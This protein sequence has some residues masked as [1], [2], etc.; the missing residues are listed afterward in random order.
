MI[1]RIVRMEFAPEKVEDFLVLFGAT[2]S[3]IRHFPGVQHLEL[4][5]DANHSNVF[6][7]YSKWENAEALEAYRVSP[8]FES[9]WS[10][11]KILFS[12]RPQ[13][14]SL[15]QEMIVE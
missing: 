3:Q 6:Y 14:F 7:T 1:T 8:L 12:G 4:H 15:I 5:R 2:K 9:V 10:R 13:A 11:T